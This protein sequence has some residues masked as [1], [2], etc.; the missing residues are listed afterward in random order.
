MLEAMFGDDPEIVIKDLDTETVQEM[1]AE[2]QQAEAGVA[3]K[4]GKPSAFNKTLVITKLPL[5]PEY[6]I[7]PDF[8]PELVQVREWCDKKQDKVDKLY[9]QCHIC[10]H[11][12]Q[13]RASMLTHTRRCMKIFL[14][15]GIY[16]KSYFSISSI[17]EH[18]EKHH[19]NELDPKAKGQTSAMQTE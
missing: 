16:T 6:E 9:Y 7:D 12:L 17:A 8:W 15:C 18:A 5:V 2:A 19:D 3:K 4:Q 10:K 1:R 11:E 14:V 13:N